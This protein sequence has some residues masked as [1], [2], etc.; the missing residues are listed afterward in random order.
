MF[1]KTGRAAIL[2]LAICLILTTFA[3]AK[4]Y[5]ASGTTSG[6]TNGSLNC[7]A[8]LTVNQIIIAKGLGSNIGWSATAKTAITASV[9]NPPTFYTYVDIPYTGPA[10]TTQ[11]ATKEGTSSVTASA[12][13]P[14]GNNVSSSHKVDGKTFWG[15]WSRALSGTP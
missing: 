6:G 8:E 7:T 4:T 9:S 11:H 1:K 5:T 10:G 15:S 3:S 14:T 13:N 2:C 12:T